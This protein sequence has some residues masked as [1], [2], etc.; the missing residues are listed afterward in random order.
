MD[1]Q[2]ARTRRALCSLLVVLF[3]IST[4]N[5]PVSGQLHDK[6]VKVPR[7][8][9]I[10][11][12]AEKPPK[13]DPSIHLSP[14]GHDRAVELYRLFKTSEE[15]PDPFPTPHFIFAAKNSKHSN[16]SVETV[17]P[18]AKKL[19]L[20]INSNYQDE[21]FEKLA[22]ELLTNRKY[23]GKPILISWHHGTTPE[24]ANRL[25]AIN[26]PDHWKDSVFDRVWQIDYDKQGLVT[27]QDLPQQLLE[28]Q[29]A[30]K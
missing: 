6:I 15:R 5:R 18:L 27:F 28:L 19:K 4:S 23:A 20:T 24:L 11:R 7:R 13:D 1:F 29:P 26:A 12:H 9:M 2:A 14:E 25:G 17:T 3:A 8:V 16:R 22:Q 10:I 30:G 21:N